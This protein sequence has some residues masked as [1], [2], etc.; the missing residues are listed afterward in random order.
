MLFDYIDTYMTV[1][2][3]NGEGTQIKHINK[4]DDLDGIVMYNSKWGE[5]SPGSHAYQV[6]MVVEDDTVTAINY[7][8]GPCKIPENGYV[9][10]FLKDRTTF[11]LDNFQIGDKIV[12]DISL[13]PNYENINLAMG[14]GTLLVKDGQT[15]KNTHNI[16]GLNPRTAL[17]LD[18]DGKTLY[19]ITVDGRQ[20]DS[21]GVSLAELSEILINNGIYNAINLDGGGS[22]TMVAKNT[23]TGAN[24]VINLPSEGSLRSVINGIGIKMTATK[25]NAS[26]MVLK[27]A[28]S[29]VFKGTSTLVESL[30]YDEN[31]MYIGAVAPDVVEWSCENGKIED[32]FYYPETEGAGKVF[33]TYKNGIDENVIEASCEFTVLGDISAIYPSTKTVKLGTGEKQ[34]ISLEG[35]DKDGKKRADKPKRHRHKLHRRRVHARGQQPRR[36]ERGQCDYDN[37]VQK[38]QHAHCALL[39]KYRGGYSPPR[40]RFIA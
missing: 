36:R 18:K 30:L 29:T 34:Y 20:A 19:L 16:A 15:A 26:K 27:P 10:S 14:G 1:T 37:R 3:P 5:T 21:I 2:A 25:G 39:R 24:E 4:Y 13:Q 7:D 31:G 35:C 22:T 17:G 33:A 11:L 32:G 38:R 8:A 6:E 23:E 40:R 28:S 12:F 9:L